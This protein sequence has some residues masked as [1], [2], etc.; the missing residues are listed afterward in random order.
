M[1]T[2]GT[3]VTPRKKPVLQSKPDESPVLGVIEI[4]SVELIIER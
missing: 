2:Q 3:L 4:F 1:Y